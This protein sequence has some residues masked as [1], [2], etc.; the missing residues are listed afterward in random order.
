MKIRRK[1]ILLIGDMPGWA[2]DNIIKFVYTQLKGEFNFYY[3]YT[4]YNPRIDSQ[5][6]SDI[7]LIEYN[8]YHGNNYRKAIPLQRIPILRAFIYYCIRYLNKFGFLS[9]DEEGRTRKVRK[10]NRYDLV[11][12]LDFYMDKDADFDHLRYNKKIRGIYTDG[13]PPK[14]IQLLASINISEFC[15]QYLNDAD[16]IVTGAPSIAALYKKHAN[17]PFFFANMAYNES[18]FKPMNRSEKTDF[19]VGWTGNPNRE[20]KGFHSVILPVVHKLQKEGYPVVLKTQFEGSIESLAIFW[21]DVDLAIIASEADA[22]PSMFMEASLCGV[23]SISTRIGMPAYLV[24]DGENGLFCERN[25]KDIS[26]KIAFLID[27]PKV[28][29]SMKACIRKDYIE[30]LGVEAQKQRWEKIFNAMLHE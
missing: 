12:F 5:V 21:Q 19:V 20:F 7:S 17:I 13:F 3:D 1:K 25:V 28:L 15:S 14:G 10:D 8:H 23:P 11:V 29:R 9:F 2:F 27:N 16:A 30:K 18:V 4:I 26:S 24:R 22:G 6:N